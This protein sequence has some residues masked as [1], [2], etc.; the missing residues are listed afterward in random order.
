MTLRLILAGIS[1]GLIAALLLS[2]G[3]NILELPLRREVIALA[4]LEQPAST[5]E[6]DALV[7]RNILIGIIFPT[8]LAAIY[9]QRA[10]HPRA[11]GWG[12]A[13]LWG[14]G[15]FIALV[16]APALSSP[17]SLYELPHQARP[18]W[19]LIGA[20]G[21][22]IGLSLLSFG[23]RWRWF[24]VV[25]LL[26]PP[27]LAPD[28]ATDEVPALFVYVDLGLDLLFWLA[29]ALATAWVLRR[30]NAGFSA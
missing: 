4:G 30:M 5:A 17:P 14:L 16:L 27:L 25:P 29:L 24:G 18:V 3:Q 6:M 8:V 20:A 13:L 23:Q 15:G 9:T 26:L 28:S 7:L 22:L 21:A 19:W 1:G 12:E 11:V 2:L 10:P